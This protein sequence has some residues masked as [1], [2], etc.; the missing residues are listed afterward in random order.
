MQESNFRILDI[1]IK[2][3]KK[4]KKMESLNIIN[5]LLFKKMVN[6]MFRRKQFYKN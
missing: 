4:L 6:F 2:N 5:Y 3:G 1:Q